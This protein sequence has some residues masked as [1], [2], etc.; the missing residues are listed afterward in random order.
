MAE[1]SGRPRKAG[2]ER[3]HIRAVE[4]ALSV[5]NAFT[6]SS[7]ELS[8]K[9]I[10]AQTGL[11]K[12][13]AFRI[14]STLERHSYIAF[15]PASVSYRLGSKLLEL[16][17]VAFSS[18]E[19]RKVARPFLNRLQADTGSTVLLATL[20]DDALV[21]ID[22]RETA[23]P[24]RIAS[25][26]G[27]RRSPHYGML[28]QV[29]MAYQEPDEVQRLLAASPLTADTPYS[30]STPEAFRARLEQ[31]RCN[32]YV[33]ELNEAIEGVWGVAAPVLA[34]DS[35]VVAAVGVASPVS[36]RSQSRV[37]ELVAAVRECARGISEV[38][39]YRPERRNDAAPAGGE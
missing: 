35:R 24:I 34:F 4:R 2:S 7:H 8:L 38:M 15:D 32:G 23:G 27:W 31:I 39:G 36:E 12:P 20:M 29:L 5:L 26:I 18:L 30:L 33:V 25:D 17:G 37:S 11:S 3:Y 28:G 9:E 6:F 19:L 1:R 22:K 14:L 21:Y 13:T 16:G 10:A